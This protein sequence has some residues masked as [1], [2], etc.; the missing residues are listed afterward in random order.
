MP[1]PD[2]TRLPCG[3]RRTVLLGGLA[4][5]VGGGVWN[6]AKA[7]APVPGA[8]LAR[9]FYR[10]EDGRN[11][12]PAFQRA[13]D[14]AAAQDASGVFND[15][16]AVTRE[17]WCPPRSPGRRAGN[18]DGI[19]LVVRAPMT[20][21]FAGATFNLKGPGGGHRMAGQRVPGLAGPWLGGWLHVIGGPRFTRI[22]VRN[23]IVD[24]GFAG[25]TVTNAGSNVTDKGFR[26]QD[27][28]VREVYMSD[29]E[30]RNFAGEIYYIGGTGPRYQQV[31]RCHFHGS[32]Q[33][34]WNPGGTGRVLAVD[35]RAGR[36][37]QVAE[38]VGGV[39][40]TYRGGQFYD[41]GNG[42][43]TFMGGPSPGFRPGYPYHYAWWDGRGAAPLV[44]FERTRFERCHVVQLGSWMRGN[45]VMVDTTLYLPSQWGHLRDIDLAIDSICDRRG[46]AEAV[47]LFGIP[48]RA[49]QIRGAPAGAF[50]QPPGDIRLRIHCTR[51]AA[52]AAANRT[53]AYAFR[54]FPGLVDGRT[55]AVTISGSARQMVDYFGGKG[56]TGP[57]PAIIDGG[58]TAQR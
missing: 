12:Q 55:I 9:K 19:P 47:A 23:V 37:Y 34:A 29:V 25:Q 57:G 3:N 52:A 2:F 42:G 5:L 50:L 8:L 20:L 53:H 45:P 58:F 48:D 1:D 7:A 46:G 21:D 18:Q 40:H 10:A 28:D 33:C 17:M 41:A 51:T 35:L 38:V 26:I 24:G 15:F 14:A 6:A 36:A 44:T 32:P 39:G 27:T 16:G 49:A 13:I 54:L 4:A 43:A 56:A 31:E 30:L 22:T 11:L